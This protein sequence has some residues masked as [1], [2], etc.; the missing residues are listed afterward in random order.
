MLASSSMSS[1]QNSTALEACTSPMET[2]DVS[3][4]DQEAVVSRF[5]TL[6]GTKSALGSGDDKEKELLACFASSLGDDAIVCTLPSLDMKVSEAS[7]NP[8]PA[9][10]KHMEIDRPR[11]A[12]GDHLQPVMEASVLGTA[13][14]TS[15]NTPKEERKSAQQLCTMTSWTKSSIVYASSALIK[16]VSNSFS[17]L[18]D[19]RVRSWTLLMFKNSLS[20]GDNSSRSNLLKMLSASVKVTSAQSNFKTLPFPGGAGGQSKEADVILPLLFE[21]SLEVSLQGSTESVTLRAPGTVS[22]NTMS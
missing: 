15:T 3:P 12:H 7:D 14:E 6:I 11:E 13:A 8:L 21:V 2:T 5:A 16:N 20:S 1:L 18:V 9:V 19:A 22:G 10:G 4:A 17:S